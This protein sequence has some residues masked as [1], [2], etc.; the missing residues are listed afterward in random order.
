[1]YVLISRDGQ[2]RSIPLNVNIKQR[3]LFRRSLLQWA[4]AAASK[5]LNARAKVYALKFQGHWQ[6]LD[7]SHPTAIKIFPADIGQDS[8]EM[9]LV[10]RERR[11]A[12]KER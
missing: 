4:T 3:G 9:W 5:V 11:D 8:V 7:V 6:V 2:I 1:M 12:D 10:Y